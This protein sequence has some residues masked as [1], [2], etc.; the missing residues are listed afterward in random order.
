MKISF[1]LPTS[2]LKNFNSFAT[3]IFAIVTGLLSF[4]VNYWETVKTFSVENE[5]LKFSEQGLF[6]IIYLANYRF[7]FLGIT[8]ICFSSSIFLVYK[9]FKEGQEN[10]LLTSF[11]IWITTF[12]ITLFYMA[13]PIEWYFVLL[14]ILWL[15]FLVY[16]FF[17]STN[18]FSEE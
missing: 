16:F 5:L 10:N 3:W 17:K 4:I 2:P 6:I 11:L 15:A 13:S 7:V 18:C 12:S 1:S 14:G 8:I 9:A